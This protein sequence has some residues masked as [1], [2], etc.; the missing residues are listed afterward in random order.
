M[1]D[2]RKEVVRD[3]SES[4]YKHIFSLLV[5]IFGFI[6]FVFCCLSVLTF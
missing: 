1:K 6:C 2:E 4:N 3:S 5:A